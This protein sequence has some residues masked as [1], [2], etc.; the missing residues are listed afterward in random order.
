MHFV[1]KAMCI[2]YTAYFEKKKISPPPQSADHKTL[3]RPQRTETHFFHK[4]FHEILLFYA[5]AM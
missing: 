1:T 5:Q 4:L 3:D 2:P